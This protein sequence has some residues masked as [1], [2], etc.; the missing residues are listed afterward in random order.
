[1]EDRQLFSVVATDIRN[2]P[3][4]FDPSRKVALTD[5]EFRIAWSMIF[6]VH[7]FSIVFFTA[8]TTLYWMNNGPSY[9]GPLVADDVPYSS[10]VVTKYTY[11]CL[12]II[13]TVELVRMIYSSFQRREM[14]LMSFKASSSV[15]AI[16]ETTSQECGEKKPEKLKLGPRIKSFFKLLSTKVKAKASLFERDG[17]HFD[18]GFFVRE[19]F[20]I[21]M[22]THLAYDLS[23]STTR[24]WIVDLAVSVLI[25][26]CTST[27]LLRILFRNAPLLSRRCSYLVGNAILSFVYSVLVPL[28]LI[29]PYWQYFDVTTQS[30]PQ[31]L[32]V[33]D[34]WWVNAV[35]EN[36]HITMTSTMDFVA[37]ITPHASL[38]C[39]ISSIKSMLRR[40]ACAIHGMFPFPVQTPSSHKMSGNKPNLTRGH[41]YQPTK[42]VSHFN[43]SMM[44]W[45]FHGVLVGWGLSIF[46]LHSSARNVPLRGCDAQLDAWFAQNTTCTVMT[47][48]CKALNSSGQ[49]ADISAALEPIQSQMLWVLTITECP[50]LEIPPKLREFT[51]LH[52]IEI[53]NSTIVQWTEEAAIDS[54]HHPHTRYALVAST[55][56]ISIPRGLYHSDLPPLFDRIGFIKTNLSVLPDTMNQ[57]WHQ[58]QWFS[59]AFSYSQLQSIPSSLGQ[60]R[61]RQLALVGNAIEQL[62]SDLFATSL[63]EVLSLSDNP[64][65]ALPSQLGDTSRLSTFYAE[66]TLITGVPEWLDEWASVRHQDGPRQ[67]W[68]F[69]LYGSPY[70]GN[71]STML[72]SP[73]RLVACGKQLSSADVSSPLAL[74]WLQRPG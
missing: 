68:R 38:I 32:L 40:H 43:K 50:S 13:H 30:Y 18:A 57:I 51:H 34:R 20:E 11:L 16:P 2:R 36:R 37:S 14:A 21:V 66:D 71:Q 60:L 39:G 52:G 41:Q 47:I 23:Q 9:V 58:R 35:L 25:A 17:P 22:Q 5:R 7:V 53:Y 28:A 59:M 26:S 64:L 1:M 12:A 33:D 62:P 73:W 55:N 44:Q 67:Q 56:V 54:Q 63:F 61:V 3:V 4:D 27:L 46:A 24:R 74:L 10:I 72:S 70:C 69:S 8:I 15:L 65:Q 45:F 48:D 49:E 29:Y 19:L 31:A 6:L 42:R